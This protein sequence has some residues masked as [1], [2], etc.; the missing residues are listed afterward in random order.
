M[1]DSASLVPDRAVLDAFEL[2]S[3]SPRRAL[4]GLIN[5]TWYVQSRGGTPLV[6][7]RVS[8]IFPPTVNEDIAAVTEHLAAKGVLTPRLV[9][10]RGGALWLEHGGEVWRV[11]T[12]VDGVSRD[13]V[14]SPA[15]ARAA[16]RVL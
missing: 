4:S 11:L 6:L 13:A 1:P 16:G 15:Q 5:P 9:P 8:S 7:Q 12:F 3:G 2:A 14:E 10:T